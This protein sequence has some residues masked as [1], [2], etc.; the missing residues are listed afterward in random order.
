[1]KKNN[2]LFYLLHGAILLCYFLINYKLLIYFYHQKSVAYDVLPYM[3]WSSVFYFGGGILLGLEKFMSEVKKEGRWKV[4]WP[5]AVILGIPSLFFSAIMFIP[6]DFISFYLL[7]PNSSTLNLVQ[8]LFGY[9][10]ITS[11]IRVK[12]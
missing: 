7:V 10:L 11:F 8:V 4:N 5:K 9:V 1:M 2:W 12:K 3:I 6:I